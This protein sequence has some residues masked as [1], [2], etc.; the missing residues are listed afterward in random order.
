M[1]QRKARVSDLAIEV[2]A[3]DGQQH[4]GDHSYRKPPH[5]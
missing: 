1:Q 4:D 5:P 3:V 2:R